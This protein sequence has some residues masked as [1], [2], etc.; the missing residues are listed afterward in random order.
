M[1][2][3][4]MDSSFSEVAILSRAIHRDKAPLPPEAAKALLAMD[5]TAE[6]QERMRTL[7]TKAA[8]GKLSP[9]ERRE[10]ESYTRVSHFLAVLHSKA[11]LS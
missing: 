3:M 11:R 1:P 6:D 8:A 9:D 10:L 5:L 4:S 2:A 7:S